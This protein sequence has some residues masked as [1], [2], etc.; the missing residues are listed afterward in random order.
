MLMTGREW[1]SMGLKYSCGC[2]KCIADGCCPG[3]WVVVAVLIVVAVCSR[4]LWIVVV[5]GGVVVTLVIH[6][7]TKLL[8]D[9]K[10]NLVE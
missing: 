2:A 10:H 1:S 8:A 4:L 7:K 5:I 9:Q 3:Q 6:G